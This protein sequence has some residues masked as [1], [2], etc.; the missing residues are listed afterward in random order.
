MRVINDENV[1]AFSGYSTAHT[2]GEVV[3]ALVCIPAS[4]GLAVCG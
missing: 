2:N 1:S 4:S 3:T